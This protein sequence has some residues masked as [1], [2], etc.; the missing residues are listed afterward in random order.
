MSGL[1]KTG[2]KKGLLPLR[3]RKI[4]KLV[5][6]I[7]A[8]GL[9]ISSAFAAAGISDAFSIVNGQFYDLGATTGNPDYQNA[10]LGAFDPAT[11]QIRL[12]G[13]QKSFQ[14]GSTDVFGSFLQYRIYLTLAGPGG[15]FSSIGEPLQFNLAIPGERQWGTEPQGSNT[16]D[17]AV[18]ISLA[19]FAPGSYTL[20]LSSFIITNGSG[21]D[22]QINNDNG[23]SNFQASFVVV[24]EPSSLT[25]VAGP[26]LLGAWFLLGRRSGHK[27]GVRRAPLAGVAV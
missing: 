21:A 10:F 25:L 8:F 26:S 2:R 17:R 23:G 6:P 22:R 7:V 1:T 14:N 3:G 13:Q 5:A 16:T 20:E 18:T 4:T 27:R 12:G 19:G 11:G 9:A 24:P 15:S